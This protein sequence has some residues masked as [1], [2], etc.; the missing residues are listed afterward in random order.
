MT[1]LYILRFLFWTG[2]LIGIVVA[3]NAIFTDLYR[4]KNRMNGLC[5][6]VERLTDT[7]KTLYRIVDSLDADSIPPLEPQ[8]PA[9]STKSRP[10]EILGGIPEES[11]TQ[12]AAEL[13]TQM[14]ELPPPLEE[15]PPPLKEQPP[16]LEELPP[17]L[18]EFYTTK[19]PICPR[20]PV[21]I[22]EPFSDDE[23]SYNQ[24]WQ[25]TQSV[26]APMTRDYEFDPDV[27]ME[28]DDVRPVVE[29]DNVSIAVDVDVID[30]VNHVSIAVEPVVDVIDMVEP[31]NDAEHS[32]VDTLNVYVSHENQMAVDVVEDDMSL[33]TTNT[34]T[35][36]DV[37]KLTVKELRKLVQSRGL[38]S[39][40][41]KLN[42]VELLALV[43]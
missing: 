9:P 37:N 40:V 38:H 17:P 3:F 36:I 42:R 13:S 12:I 23:S 24:E 20:I 18:K 5:N 7:T 4:T 15:L 16:P 22:T 26:A 30:L 34:L 14:E 31:I 6:M 21:E 19:Y 32:S 43:A 8:P 39:N 29:I 10:C 2:C 41:A 28:Y 11:Y 25:S 33:I 1:F 35:G 27:V